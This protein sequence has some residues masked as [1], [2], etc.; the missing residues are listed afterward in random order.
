MPE[1]IDPSI[2]I[3]WDIAIDTDSDPNTGWTS[4]LF[5]DGIGVD[6]LI[7]VGILESTYYPQVMRTQ[8]TFQEVA[9]P[10]CYIKDNT[11]LFA[12]TSNEFRMP[13]NLIWMVAIFKFGQ[14]GQPPNPPLL[15]TDIAPN[16][17]HYTTSIES[18]KSLS[19]TM[20]HTPMTTT[21]ASQSTAP[22]QQERPASPRLE[23]YL[24]PAVGALTVFV[25]AFF[26]MVRKK[27][28]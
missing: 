11:I 6:Y 4:S 22:Q 25:V 28:R 1:K 12:V 5:Y 10:R 9:R 27:Q 17:R 15:A 2:W 14:R 18:I 20:T 26:R 23:L 7:R 8:P 24:I 21:T 16:A 3:E 19:E 13:S